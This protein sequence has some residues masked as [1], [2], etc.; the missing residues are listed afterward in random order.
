[1]RQELTSQ[2]QGG[3]VT[4]FFNRPIVIIAL[5]LICIGVIGWKAWPRPKADPAAMFEQGAQLMASDDP[6][7]WNRAW[8]EFLEPL[9]R[10]RLEPQQ[11]EELD[12]FRQ[13]INDHDAR[14][15]AAGRIGDGASEAQHFYDLGQRLCLARDQ[16]GARR[17]WENLV[18]SFDG[19]EAEAFWVRLA[20]QGLADLES[21]A[22]AEHRWDSVHQ[23]LERA[24]QFRDEG[25]RK[26]AEVIWKGIEELYQGDSSAKEIL[27]EIKKDR[28]S[29]QH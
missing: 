12:R 14:R 3:P 13:L 2:K 18:H 15:R 20:K 19:V 7:D 17:V 4:Q 25:K 16:L 1:M 22:P 8:T 11:Q 24:R 21:R 27:A 29:P 26:D 10:H 9:E 23:A 28:A 5:L 6:A